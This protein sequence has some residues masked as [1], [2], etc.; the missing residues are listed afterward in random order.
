MRVAGARTRS[1]RARASDGGGDGDDD[2][3]FGGND[4]ASLQQ[5]QR[6]RRR[7]CKPSWLTFVKRWVTF[8]VVFC[9]W[10]LGSGAFIGLFLLLFCLFSF[11][12]FFFLPNC[13]RGGEGMVNGGR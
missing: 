1:P 9:V 3:C 4:E 12:R 8:L 7:S 6:Q 13:Y 2:D 5:P 10:G 11:S